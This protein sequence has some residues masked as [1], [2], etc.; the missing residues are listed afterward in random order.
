MP[1]TAAILVGGRAQRLGG[2]DKSRLDVG[3]R[4]ILDHQLD[5]LAGVVDRVVLIGSSDGPPRRPGVETVAD[6]RPG[7]GSLGGIHTALHVAAGPVLVVACDMP[8]LTGAFLAFLQDALGGHDA[9]IPR[10]PDGLHPLCAVYAQ[11]CLAPV[12]RRLDTGRL[13][14]VDALTGLRIRE[15]GPHEI[16]PFD[17]DGLLFM[18]LNTPDDLSRAVA[19]AGRSGA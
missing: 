13:K 11:T 18:N 3:G 16:E 17:P 2:L 1:K 7:C 9:V 19:R 6:I 5:A 4:A 10:T 12:E 14:V 8:F 15:I